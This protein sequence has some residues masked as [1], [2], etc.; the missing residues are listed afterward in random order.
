MRG[1]VR[2]TSRSGPELVRWRQGRC[3]PYGEGIAFWALGEIVKAECGILE[4]DSPAGGGGE[5][6]A[7]R[8]PQDE[9]DRPWLRAR[10]AP[11]V[12]CGG[13]AG[14]AGGVVHGLA[15]LPG[16]AGRGGADGARVRGPALGRRGAARLPRAPGRLVARACRCSCSARRGRS[17]TSSIRPG[18]PGCATRPRSTSPR[19][20][21]RRPPR[22][23]ASLLERAVLP[24][25]D[26]AGA[27]RAGGRQ[28]AVRGGVRAPAR[29]PRASWARSDGGAGL[30]AGADRRPPGHALARAQEPAPGRGRGRARCSG[31]V[32]WPRWAA[33]TRARSSWRCTSCRARSSSARSR[34]S[35]MEGESRVRLLAPAGPGRLLRPDPARRPRRPPPRRGRLD[36]AS[37]GRAGRGPGRRARPPLPERAR[38]RRAPPAKR[39]GGG[40]GG[41]RDPLPGAGRRARARA[42]RRPRRGRAWPRRSRSPPPAIPSA[43]RCSSAGR[44]RRSSRAGS[45]RH[46]PRSRRRS[47]STASR[48]RASPPGGR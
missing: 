17:C 34:E 40:A 20:P 15:A 44:R 11:L 32:R 22:L 8:C 41:E 5:A 45:R 1:A 19:S 13:G 30:G 6:G 47:P 10:L 29:R 28:P 23:I 26:A 42:R 25:G 12:G 24:R 9:P 21:T 14:V 33:A 18:R 27:A 37:G 46:E 16:G 31:R 48:T 7:R 2:A 43:R 4:S 38:A 36:R 35:S 39:G 3:L